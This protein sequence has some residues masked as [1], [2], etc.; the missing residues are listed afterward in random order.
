MILG[1]I[2]NLLSYDDLDIRKSAERT[3]QLLLQIMDK[4]KND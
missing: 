3:N 1:P 4:V 2:L